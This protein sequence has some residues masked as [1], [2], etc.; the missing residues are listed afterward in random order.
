MKHWAL[1]GIVLGLCGCSDQKT[2]TKDAKKVEKTPFEFGK[3]LY[4]GGDLEGAILKFNQAQEVD[5]NEKRVYYWRGVCYAE[6]EKY[7]Q[8]LVEFNKSIEKQPKNNLAVYW[9]GM[10]H[11]AL[12]DYDKSLA[13]F[14]EAIKRVPDRADWYYARSKV[15]EAKGD[16]DKAA[17]DQKRAQQVAAI[18]IAT[19]EGPPVGYP[20]EIHS[21]EDEKKK[22]ETSVDSQDSASP[23]PKSE[24]AAP[25]PPQPPATEEPKTDQKP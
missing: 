3:M 16:K 13:D 6:L 20:G 12:K 15:W 24:P 7:E 1:L 25:N 2:D 22:Q 9:R 8:A 4:E 18:G 21:K 19:P 11:F 10:T 17:A 23:A 5:P 14:D